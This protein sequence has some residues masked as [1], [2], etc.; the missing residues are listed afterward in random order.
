MI[1]R[2]TPARPRCRIPRL[3]L[4]VAVLGLGLLASLFTAWQV[5]E[6]IDHEALAAFTKVCDE[7]TLKVNERL[8]AYAL[9]LQG[10]QALFAASE[11]VERDEWRAYVNTVRA[12]AIVPGHQGLGFSLL[13]AP[14]DLA[15]HEAAVRDEGFPDYR[16]K[17]PEPREVYSSIV[18][19]E[20]FAGRNLRAFGYDMFSEPVRRAAME[21]ARDTGLAALT[22]KVILMQEEDH[23]VQP[24]ALMYVPV[25][26]PH[27][28]VDT[29]A[30]R[31]RALLGWVYSPYRMH[32]LMTGIIPDWQ[33]LG[34]DLVDLHV[35]DGDR[36]DPDNLLFDSDPSGAVHGRQSILH[37]ER[38]ID[39]NGHHWLLVF[40]GS[41]T[42]DRISYAP[43]WITAAGGVVISGLLS[44]LLLTLFKRADAQRLAEGYAA[45]I[46]DLAFYDSLTGLPNRRLLDDRL[47]MAL[48]AG[49]RRAASGALLLLDLDNFK[50]LN[51]RHGHAAGDLL[52]QEVARRL[53]NCVRETDTV[54]RLGGDEFIILLPAL[55]GDAAQA[56][57]R[58]LEIAGQIRRALEQPFLLRP[59]PSAPPIEHRCPC[60]IGLTLLAPDE[61]NHATIFKRADI[62]MYDAKK[63]GRN[64]ISTPRLP[65]VPA[66]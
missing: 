42:A 55:A 48:A 31:R 39:F 35:Y 63:S 6:N 25:Y 52:L 13:I 53:Q 41:R 10:G 8:T 23:D 36:P 4:A 1:A 58:A 46:R 59:D 32:D 29:V 33:I 47:A 16:V 64:R 34:D 15:G 62:A 65:E 3:L 22:G 11:S 43:A 37:T 17:P 30:E 57:G 20:P 5:K 49:H 40:N 50:P 18:Y 14:E 19:L 12:E 24:G 21:K 27:A 66:A 9:L 44:G 38:T 61:T 28:P 26:R 45:Q 7:V 51:D 2:D 56:R 60:S 54:A